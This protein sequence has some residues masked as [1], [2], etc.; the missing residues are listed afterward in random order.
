M[1]ISSTRSREESSRRQKWTGFYTYATRAHSQKERKRM[2]LRLRL[3]NGRMHGSGTD[4]EIGAFQIDG[5]YQPEG[6]EV[7]FTKAYPGKHTILYLGY[8]EEEYGIWGTWQ[9]SR[10][11]SP[12]GSFH[13]W[14][15]RLL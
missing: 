2:K 1:A 14:N 13:I 11:T 5:R 6:N 4:E 15:P 3:E 10:H 9:I 8:Y 7:E 12:G